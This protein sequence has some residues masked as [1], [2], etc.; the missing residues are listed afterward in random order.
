MSDT[1]LPI[2]TTK[3]ATIVA[4]I[5]RWLTDRA[6]SALAQ[7]VASVAF[8][9]RVVSAGLAYVVQILLARWMGAFEFGVYAY[10]WT[11]VMLLGGLVDFGLASAAQRFIPN[12]KERRSL[13]KLR[14]FIY[15]SRWIAFWGATACTVLGVFVIRQIEPWLDEYTIVPL[16]LGCIMLPIWGVMNMQDN[17]A[18]SYNWVQVAL[19]P[20]YIMRQILLVAFMGI[21]VWIG[22]AAN[23]ATA[24]VAAGLSLWLTGLG[25]LLLLNRNLS[26]AH[27]P[28]KRAYE[29]RRWFDAAMPMLVIDALYLVLLYI[30]VIMLQQFRPPEEIAIYYAAGKTLALVSFVH[31]A[32]SAATAHRYT[33][34]HVSGNREKLARFLA[35]SIRWTFW[36]SLAATLLILACGWP[37]LRLFGAKFVDGYS[38]MFILSVGMLARAAVGPGE[39]F[40]TMLGHQSACIFIAACAVAANLTLCLVLIPRYGIIGAAIATSSAFLVE[41][42][43]LYLFAKR[44]V[45]FHLFAWRGRK[46]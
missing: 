5:H 29:W 10:V 34:Y 17:I 8:L 26:T 15:G 28:G 32:V 7:R 33:Q 20:P 22:Y 25:Q 35:D 19:L 30:D 27:R 43:L 18:R 41:S 37:M 31:F 21:A 38:V 45:G 24:I 12:Y 42:V 39:R 44:L 23:A 13:T 1:T 2:L 46:N 36:P 4:R 16:Y 40:L 14:G 9:I 3:A 11:W 6:D